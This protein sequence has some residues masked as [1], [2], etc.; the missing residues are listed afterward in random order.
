[1]DRHFK[2]QHWFANIVIE[3]YIWNALSSGPDSKGHQFSCVCLHGDRK[4]NERKNNLDRFKVRTKDEHDFL[5]RFSQLVDIL[6]PS[7]V[8]REKM[9]S[10]WSAQMWPPEESTSAV[11]LTVPILSLHPLYSYRCFCHLFSQRPVSPFTNSTTVINVT[12]PDEKQ[13]YVH[14][15][16]RV[17]RAE[18]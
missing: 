5:M 6:R 18:R 16:G 9:W 8:H 12:L 1:M 3:S 11:F 14:R 10:C 2:I 17:G 4:P 15:I 7:C 13:N